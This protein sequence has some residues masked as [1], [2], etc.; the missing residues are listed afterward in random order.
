MPQNP[1]VV[2]ALGLGLDEKAIEAVMKWR[3]QP[4]LKDG[5]P[6]TVAAQV[7]VNFRPAVARS[8]GV[9]DRLSLLRARLHPGTGR[10]GGSGRRSRCPSCA[11]RS[12]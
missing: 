12:S 1:R 8:E 11:R 7:E 5:K 2:R 3:F 10:S 4:G 6:V 9:R